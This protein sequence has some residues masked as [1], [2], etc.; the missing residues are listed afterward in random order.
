MTG[1][2]EL[3]AGKSQVSANAGETGRGMAWAILEPPSGCR[4]PT[5]GWIATGGE[6]PDFRGGR[7]PSVTVARPCRIL[8]GFLLMPETGNLSAPAAGRNRNVG[9]TLHVR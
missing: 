2:P 4:V 8:T 5:C 7:C 1:G 3:S 9:T 6:V